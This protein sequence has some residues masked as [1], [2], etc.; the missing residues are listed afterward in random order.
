M[1]KFC[2]KVFFIISSDLLCTLSKIRKAPCRNFKVFKA[3]VKEMYL[4]PLNT[5]Y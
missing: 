4:L 1:R 3:T 5:R 2:A